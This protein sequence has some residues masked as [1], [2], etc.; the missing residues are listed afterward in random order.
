MM[1]MAIYTAQCKAR[2]QRNDER[3]VEAERARVAR[4]LWLAA[5]PAQPKRPVRTRPS[6][7]RRL[8][9]ALRYADA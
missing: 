5:R 1:Q 7:F 8:F 4:R 6:A 9:I 3:W 2:A